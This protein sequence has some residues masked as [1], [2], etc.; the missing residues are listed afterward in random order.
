[1]LDASTLFIRA[2]IVNAEPELSSSPEDYAH[3]K[4]S[5]GAEA[6]TGELIQTPEKLKALDGTPAAMCIFAKLSVR[7]PGIFRLKF[8][9]FESAR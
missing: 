7:L 3:V 2:T 6:S 5:S 9:L 8:T 1:M 4:T